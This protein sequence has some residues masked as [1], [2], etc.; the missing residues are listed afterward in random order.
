MCM[1]TFARV[2]VFVVVFLL[3]AATAMLAAQPPPIEARLEGLDAYMAQVL[4]DWNVPG[5]GVG[6]VVKDKLVFVKGY[7]YRDYGKRLPFTPATTQPIASNTK[8]FSAMAAG[9]I[10]DEGKLDWDK[11]IRQ[12]VPTA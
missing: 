11:P 7:G 5:I 2:R 9:L 4:Q 3:L 12:Y 1:L 8:L 10:V 6:V